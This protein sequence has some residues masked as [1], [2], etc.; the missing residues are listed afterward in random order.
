MFFLKMS[1]DNM[2]VPLA[3]SEIASG[4]YDQFLLIVLPPTAKK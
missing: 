2:R 4:I 1:F 3:V